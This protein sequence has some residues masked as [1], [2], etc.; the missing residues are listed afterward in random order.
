MKQPWRRCWKLNN[1]IPAHLRRTTRPVLSASAAPEALL[2]HLRASRNNPLLPPV[3]ALPLPAVF[4]AQHPLAPVSTQQGRL[5]CLH[6]MAGVGRAAEVV[7]ENG[8]YCWKAG[9]NPALE[10]GFALVMPE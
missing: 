10:S 5:A 9:R 6:E 1:A 3:T 4:L 2:H 7:L 8:D